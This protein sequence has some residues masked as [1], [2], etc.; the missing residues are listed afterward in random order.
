M[1]VYLAQVL[2]RPYI[3][4]FFILDIGRKRQLKSA[5]VFSFGIFIYVRYNGYLSVI[6]DKIR[7]YNGLQKSWR[8]V[9]DR[10]W[11]S[12]LPDIQT[13]QNKSKLDSGQHSPCSL[14]PC[15]TWVT[16]VFFLVWVSLVLT[17]FWRPYVKPFWILN[18]GRE[19]ELNSA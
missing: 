11:N 10:A 14:F 7:I 15:R 18:I 9:A 19:R 3:S 16:H 12:L 13:S 4:P 6:T 1:S 5:S 2:L 17:V 8:G